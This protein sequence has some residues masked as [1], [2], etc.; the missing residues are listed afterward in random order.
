[1]DVAIMTGFLAMFG[2]GVADFIAKK[3]IDRVG[4]TTT[5]F[6]SQLLGA[7]VLFALF[8]ISQRPLNLS[9]IQY[10]T[11]IPLGIW[12][13]LA[14]LPLYDAFSKGK[15]SLISPIF[16]S[17]SVLVAILSIVFFK[18]TI[19]FAIF[20]SLCLL[21]IG[22]F[23]M[24]ARIEFKSQTTFR[25]QNI[26]GLS[27][28]VLAVILYSFWIIVFDMSLVADMWIESLL[29]VRFVA[30]LSVLAY[31]KLKKKDILLRKIFLNKNSNETVYLLFLIGVFDLFAFSMITYGYGYSEYTSVIT[32]IGSAFSLPTLILARIFLKE[33]LTKNQI[34]GAIVV[35][36]GIVT[37]SLPAVLK[38]Q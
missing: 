8:F 20:S 26:A 37:L 28:V 27:Q 29:I 12:S 24:N 35:I 18:E 23:L 9:Y 30:S 6:W 4:D 31:G 2:W 21:S 36:I 11:L 34:I 1:M 17:Y 25:I 5:L 15:V 32:M 38:I 13:G 19:S 16:A 33:H 7:S 14:Y 3:T 10:L 22:I